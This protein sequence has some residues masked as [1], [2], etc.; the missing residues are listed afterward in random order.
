MSKLS[1]T[2]IGIH[3]KVKDIKVS[4][5]FYE[6]LGFTPVFGYGSEEF[7]KSLPEGCASA[8]E[9]YQGVTYHLKDGADFEIADG[10]IAAKP[11]VFSEQ[12]TS[13]KVS[14]MIKVDSIMPVI[15]QHKDRIKFPVRKYYWG[16]IE[17]VLRDPDGFVL[18]F[19]APASDEEYARISKLEE[20]ETIEPA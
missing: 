18:V 2:G 4:R 9:K 17:V 3:L 15:Q 11:E 13:A 5:K 16:T 1:L 12:I 10:H 7:R 6:S 20:I 19:I 8:P 14:A